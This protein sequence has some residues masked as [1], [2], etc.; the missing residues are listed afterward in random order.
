MPGSAWAIPATG[1]SDGTLVDHQ[2]CRYTP[3]ASDDVVIPNWQHPYRY[4]VA[5]ADPARR[6]NPLPSPPLVAQNF[7]VVR[8]P[9]LCP[10]DVPA[11]PAGE[12][13]VN[14]NTLVHKPLP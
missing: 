3:A 13:R 2:L 4:A 5:Y 10:T 8:A 14:S 6:L 11:D 12:D 1:L 9:Y 7:L